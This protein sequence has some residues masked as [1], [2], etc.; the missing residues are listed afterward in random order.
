MREVITLEGLRKFVKMKKEGE[1]LPA[2]YRELVLHYLNFKK[3]MME[4]WKELGKEEMYELDRSI[5][6]EAILLAR[7]LGIIW[8]GGEVNERGD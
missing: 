8:T 3:S 2:N 5:L 6:D 4:K 7:E 1:K